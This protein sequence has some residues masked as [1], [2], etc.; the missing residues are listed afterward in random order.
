MTHLLVFLLCIPAFTA[1]AL[2]MERHQMDLFSHPL[3]SS[4]TR[5]LRVA[6]WSTLALALW[7]IVRYQGWALGLVSYSGHTSF[8]AGLVYGALILY[9]RRSKVISVDE[10]PVGAVQAG[11][12]ARRD[13][14]RVAGHTNEEQR[15]SAP[16]CAAEAGYSFPEIT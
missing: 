2:A 15:G 9:G 10:Y 4:T 7:V 5:C 1:L 16:V 6:G 13:E 14:C 3:A 8:G 12:A 11:C